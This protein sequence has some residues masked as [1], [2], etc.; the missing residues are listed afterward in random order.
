MMTLS[1]YLSIITLNVNGLNDPI[2]RCKVSDWIKKQDS[3]ICCLQETHLRPKDTYSLKIKG[4][5]TIYHSNSTQKKTGIAILI[6]DKLKFIPKTVV[7]DEKGHYIIVK[8][9]IQQE[10]LTIMNIYAP[11]VGAAKYINQFITKVKI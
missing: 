7:R 5:R 4:W 9:S 8:E 11:N 6:S 10:D 1:S 2:K 3:Y